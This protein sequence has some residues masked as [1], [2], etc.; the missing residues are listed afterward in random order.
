MIEA[1]STVRTVLILHS[2]WSALIRFALNLSIPQGTLD[3]HADLINTAFT[4]S[5]I[6][7]DHARYNYRLSQFYGSRNQVMARGNEAD[8]ALQSGVGRFL[9]ENSTNFQEGHAPT[10]A[11][12]RFFGGLLSFAAGYN[13]YMSFYFDHQTHDALG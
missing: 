1:L 13:C 4:S 12:S 7:F 3:E 8:K 10:V 11:L 6:S 2:F 5:A 9:R